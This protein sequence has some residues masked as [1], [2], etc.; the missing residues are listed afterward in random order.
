MTETVE[1]KR[2]KIEVPG[3]NGANPEVF[4]GEGA[5]ESDAY[6]AA[7]VNV[8]EGKAH[9]TQKIHEQAQQLAEMEA[10]L[11]PQASS[12]PAGDDF[13]KRYWDTAWQDAGAAFDMVFEQRFGI[14]TSDAVQ[15]FGDL[16]AAAKELDAI[17]IANKWKVSH[18]ELMKTPPEVTEQNAQAIEFMLREND[19]PYTEKGLDAAY[20]LAF[21]KGKLKLPVTNAETS[22]P[23]APATLTNSGGN[24]DNVD[25]ATMLAGM[26]LDQKRQYY[27]SRANR[28]RGQQ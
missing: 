1:V 4:W 23:S 7:A 3:P 25:E 16:T 6:Q 15:Q 24:G 10:R 5:T 27:S 21:Q 11:T 18:P 9:A 8:A 22:P 28:L 17:K 13:N 19:L 12:G 2:V 26:T 14:P 20:A